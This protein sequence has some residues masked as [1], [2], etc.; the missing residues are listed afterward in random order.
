MS[1]PGLHCYAAGLRR[2]L[3]L[4]AGGRRVQGSADEAMES[5]TAPPLFCIPLV[6]LFTA[7][8]PSQTACFLFTVLFAASPERQG[9]GLLHWEMSLWKP[10]T[11]PPCFLCSRPFHTARHHLLA[12][13][14]RAR[15]EH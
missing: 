13:V 15:G 4:E 5:G 3:L 8:S 1:P 2:P 9:V 6:E 7:P 12:A 11:A 14:S 10:W